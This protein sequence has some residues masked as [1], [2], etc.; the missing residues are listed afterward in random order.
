MKIFVSVGTH[1]QQFNRL[2]Q[3]MDMLLAEGRISAEVFAQAGNSDYKPENFK[4]EKFLGEA[5][6][7]EKFSWADIVVSHGGAGT[8][9]NAMLNRKR[10]V[11]VPRL[12]KFSEHTN[13][14][15]LD[16]AEALEKK[17]SA[18][19]VFEIEKLGDAIRKAE[20]FVPKISSNRESLVNAITEILEKV[21]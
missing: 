12:K 20:K 14:H 11:I 19:A 16:L 1:P 6:F 2:L 8:I 17:G 15:Q 3:R 7:E 9:I 21:K 5:E 4:F 10:L 18:I 13:D